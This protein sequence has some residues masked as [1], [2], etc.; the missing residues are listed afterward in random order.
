MRVK[1]VLQ[2]DVAEEGIADEAYIAF[3]NKAGIANEAGCTE[4]RFNTFCP[5]EKTW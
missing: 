3:A 5:R 1:E 4:E 2:K